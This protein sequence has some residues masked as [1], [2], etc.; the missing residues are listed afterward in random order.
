MPLVTVG[1]RAR[2][3]P[4]EPSITDVYG[5]VAP[6]RARRS[7]RAR[8]D[9][10]APA[11]GARRRGRA[12]WRRWATVAGALRARTAPARPTPTTTCAVGYGTAD[13]PETIGRERSPC[14]GCGGDERL[15]EVGGG[16]GYAAAVASRL[17][18]EVVATE[19]VGAAGGPGRPQAGAGGTP[20]CSR[21]TASAACPGRPVRRDPRSSAAERSPRL[22]PG[23]KSRPGRAAGAP[24]RERRIRSRVRR[25]GGPQAALAARWTRAQ[26]AEPELRPHAAPPEPDTT[27]AAARPA[28]PLA[29]GCATAATGCSWSGSARS[30]PRA[31]SSTLRLRSAAARSACLP[32]GRDG[33]VLLRG[34]QQLPV[35]PALDVPARRRR[36][37]RRSRRRASSPWPS[38]RSLQHDPAGDFVEQVGHREDRRPGAGGLPRD[39]GLVPRQQALVLPA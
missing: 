12:C 28:H 4:G 1:R 6:L 8:A 24:H 18:R 31:S 32:G 10:G 14:S 7:P 27:T 38:R 5:L 39:A 9:G 23:T 35:E 11:R 26:R 2:A 37:T 25:S 36:A 15:L 30:G 16:S 34:R 3:L 20:A 13:R 19:R 22:A 21:S 29:P 17:A 33:R